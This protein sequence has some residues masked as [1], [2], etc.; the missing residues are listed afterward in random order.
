VDV[1]MGT[2]H[3]AYDDSGNRVAELKYFAQVGGRETWEALQAGTAGGDADG[4]GVEDK[5]TLIET[6]EEF[7]D[8]AEGDTPKRV[9]GVAQAA[10]TLQMKR[11]RGDKCTDPFSVKRI[12]TV[13]TLAE[14]SRAALNVLHNDPDGL[15]LMI[16]AGA[17][18]WAGHEN[19]PE[20][21]IEEGIDFNLA[22]EA[23]VDWIE[24]QS[25]WE[26]TLL[27]VTADHETGYLTGPG[28]DPAKSPLVPASFGVLPGMEWHSGGHTN[29]LVPFY[30]KG[31]GAGLFNEAAQ[32]SDPIHGAYLD[33]T[34]L[35]KIMIQ[36]HGG[37]VTAMAK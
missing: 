3:P 24:T 23:V 34:D 7:Q 26:E 10:Q 18:D 11:A 20:R 19:W 27:I 31:A 30:A 14:M 22:V 5:W 2:G 32:G 17:I 8:L 29:Q 4:D 25:S 15:F 37:T 35:G 21:L 13:P 6:R 28:S 9:I 33:N 1:I 12:L 16:E 36:L